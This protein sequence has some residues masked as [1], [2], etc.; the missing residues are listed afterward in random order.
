MVGLYTN[1]KYV[2]VTNVFRDQLD[3]YGE[4]THTLN[5]IRIGLVRF[6]GGNSMY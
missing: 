1:P 6:T 4:I 2:L 3:R 5:N